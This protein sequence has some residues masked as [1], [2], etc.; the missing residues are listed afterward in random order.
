MRFNNTIGKME[1]HPVEIKDLEEQRTKQKAN[2]NKDDDYDE[3]D[4]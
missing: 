1:F 2:S 3:F 4:N